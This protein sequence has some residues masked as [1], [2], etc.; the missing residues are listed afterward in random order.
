MP[1]SMNVVIYHWETDEEQRAD[2]VDPPAIKALRDWFAEHAPWAIDDVS[3]TKGQGQV[4]W[5]GDLLAG[6]FTWPLSSDDLAEAFPTFGWEY[7][8]MAVLLIQFE[9]DSMQ[10]VRGDGA[11][12]YWDCRGSWHRPPGPPE[13]ID[14]AELRVA[15]LRRSAGVCVHCGQPSRPSTVE[16]P[17]NVGG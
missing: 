17:A 10:V 1:Q 7:P 11:V 4:W 2:L 16:P 6:G 5:G 9:S 8:E 3:I 13:E 14:E 15:A 12:M